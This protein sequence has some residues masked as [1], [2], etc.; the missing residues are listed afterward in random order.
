MRVRPGVKQWVL[1]TAIAS[2]AG[3]G[4]GGPAEQLI[5]QIEIRA[6]G[7]FGVAVPSATTTSFE[8][9]V[10]ATILI[11]L[12]VVSVPV[13]SRDNVGVASASVKDRA[14]EDGMGLR[15]YEFFAASIPERARGLNRLGF[16]REAAFVDRTGIRWTAHFGVVSST[17]EATREEAEENLDRQTRFETYTVLDGFTDPDHA[18]STTLQLELEGLW[19]TAE[20]L[21][22]DVRPL[23]AATAPDEER[24]LRIERDQMYFEPVGFLG[25][26]ERS[27]LV[28]A[29]D[30][31]QGRTP[32][33]FRY[34]FVHNGK[35]FYLDMESH[36]IDHERQERYTLAHLV[37]PGAL[38]HRLNYQISDDN[39]DRV[40][41]FD[42]WTELPAVRS[43]SLSAPILPIAFEF[44]ARSFLELRVVRVLEK[45]PAPPTE[46]R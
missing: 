14:A 10:D 15:T 42:V 38:V 21:Y 8:Y 22:S 32:R 16:L 25:A 35:L 30:A 31:T 46:T 11:P 27:L 43:D 6:P 5:P 23:W 37:E 45:L 26:I 7:A 13:G 41:S 44:K 12:L 18:W 17:R 28:A 34:P 24:V 2:Q 19:R 3:V 1:A 40:Q 20:T 36:S 33:R 39:G 4:L 9:Q 29:A